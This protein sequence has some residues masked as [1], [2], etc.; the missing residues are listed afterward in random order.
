LVKKLY[1]S[2]RV[3]EITEKRVVRPMVALAG[4][5]IEKGLK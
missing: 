1:Q 2:L 4:F 3:G 5:E